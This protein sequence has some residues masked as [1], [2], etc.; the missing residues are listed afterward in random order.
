VGF[1]PTAQDCSAQ[2]GLVCQPSLSESEFAAI[3][4]ENNINHFSIHSKKTKNTR[5]QIKSQYTKPSNFWLI[6]FGHMTYETSEI[7]SFPKN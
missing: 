6:D 3:Y 7:H 4:M 5:K 1:P 2:P